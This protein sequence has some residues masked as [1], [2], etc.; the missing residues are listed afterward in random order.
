MNVFNRIAD[1]SATPSTVKRTGLA[2]LCTLGFIAGTI[3]TSPAALAD[4]LAPSPPPAPVVDEELPVMGEQLGEEA[5]ASAPEDGVPHLFSP[6]NLP[7]GTSAEPIG[8]PQGRN[9]TYLRELWHALRTQ[10]VTMSDAY[11]LF[12]Q[13]PL[14]PDAKPPRGLAAGPQPLPA[15]E[16]PAAPPSPPPPPAPAE[17]SG[18]ADPQPLPPAPPLPLVP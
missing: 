9:M 14:N 15:P 2:G 7:P 8:N 17:A 18:E 5:V 10:D 3:A 6:D 11:F 13:R 12:T 16:P 1:R 4:P